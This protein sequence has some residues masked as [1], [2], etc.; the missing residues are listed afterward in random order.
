MTFQGTAIPTGVVQSTYPNQMATALPGMLAN[1]TDTNLV[2][3]IVVASADGILA[4]RAAFFA[5]QAA[6]GAN[7]RS[8]INAR[9]V[10][11][12][13][14]AVAAGTATAA[15]FAGVALRTLAGFSATAQAPLWPLNVLAPI[16]RPARSGAR[17]WV[18]TSASDTIVI[19]DS[20]FVVTVAAAGYLIGTFTNTNN[21]GGCIAVLLYG[22][23]FQSNSA[24]STVQL[25]EFTVP[26]ATI[27]AA[28]ELALLQARSPKVTITAT[29]EDTHHRDIT[30]TVRDADG[31][32]IAAYHEIKLRINATADRGAATATATDTFGA[33][34]L[35]G[36]AIIDTVTA[37]AEYNVRTDANGVYTFRLTH[38]DAGTSRYLEAVIGGISAVSGAIAFDAV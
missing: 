19:G 4:G 31:V 18:E 24:A 14:G 36:S 26:V 3:S 1:A 25:V 10:I 9:T 15:N 8:G 37:K 30:L 29:A 2:D 5:A 21:S 38:N 23:T 28:S 11:N 35:P 32:A 17:L 6:S 13:T 27:A 22:A 20:V 16:A 33:P 7:A 34:S 12:T